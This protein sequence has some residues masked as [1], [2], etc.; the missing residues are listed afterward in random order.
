MEP[1]DIIIELL[2]DKYN[3][4]KIYGPV[5][6]YNGRTYFSRTRLIREMTLEDFVSTILDEVEENQTVGIYKYEKL[7]NS[8]RIVIFDS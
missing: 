1:L 4:V 6:D 3:D 5:F 7:T 8:L 2:G